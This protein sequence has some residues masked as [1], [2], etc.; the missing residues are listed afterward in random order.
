[1]MISEDAGNTFHFATFNVPGAPNSTV[2]PVT[3]PGEFT[4][5]GGTV[6]GG[7]IS[8]NIRLTIHGTQSPGPGLFGLPR[9]V[10]ASRMTL[11]PAAAARNGVVY[12]A[13]NN[14]ASMVLGGSAGSNVLFIRS[15]DGGQTWTAPIQVNPTVSTDKHHV[16]PSLAIDRNGIG[17]HVSWY[18]QHTDTTIDLDMAN[19]L[20]RGDTFPADRIARVTSTSFNLPPTNI[21]LTNAPVFSATNYDRQIAVCY[22]LGEYQGITSANGTVYDAWGDMRNKLTEPTNTLDPISGQMH[23]EEN[24]FFQAVKAQ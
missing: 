22:A 18:T 2:M 7:R 13:W 3:Q 4:S 6:S 21:P 14:S 1:M 8:A 20:D 10:N 11:Q 12:L 16:L 5:C 9:Y 19:S 23:T 24:V 15:D 17:V